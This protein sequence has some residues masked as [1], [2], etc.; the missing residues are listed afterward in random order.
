MQSRINFLVLVI[1]LAL[2]SVSFAEKQAAVPEKPVSANQA[3]DI[4]I[5]PFPYVAEMIAD[6]VNVRSGPGTNYYRCGKLN[7]T[8]RIKVVGSKFSWSRIVPPV[9]SFSWI[10]K[11]YV[12]IDPNNTV[13]GTVTG[14][15]VRVYAGSE[16]VK[17][18][19]STT[20]QVKLNEGDRV[21]LLGDEGESDYH[22]IVPPVGSYLWVSTNYT[23]SLGPVGQVKII[24]APT[25]GA[26]E[27]VASVETKKLREYYAL[28]K[29]VEDQ[30]AK[31]IIQQDYTNIKKALLEIAENEEAGK[32]ARYS[33]FAARQIGRFE[34][35]VT[36]AKEVEL[37][38]KQLKQ[39][40]DGIEKA[41]TARLAEVKD[42]GKFTA[43]GRFQTS[44]IY[45]EEQELKHYRV[46]D[47]SGKT[48]CYALP[49]E[50]AS[51]M[52]LDKF[53]G[54]EVG[55]IGTV[56]P[57][58]ETSNALVRFDQIVELK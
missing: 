15:S 18:I 52:D 35:A 47:D 53:I 23:K 6:N 12:K 16:E 7:K 46:I 39:I 36:V 41:R 4:N 58:L 5:P 30:R 20:V 21:G 26:G 10:S 51:G 31:P 29:Q 14:D 38:N 19:H 48:V 22:K 3:S 43:V 54:L 28:Q 32:A 44:K 8:D 25:V 17:P 42:L 49:S 56:E 45:G 24:V 34:L 9:G 55:L 33:K 50:S 1:L 27:V 40:R 2:A 37:Q 13:V 11:Q 57:H